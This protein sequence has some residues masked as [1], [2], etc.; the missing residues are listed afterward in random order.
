M[1][2]ATD[3]RNGR[4][5][6][7]ETTIGTAP[8][9]ELRSGTK[10]TDCAAADTGTQVATGVLPSDWLAAA[11]G[12]VKGKAGTWT[13]TGVAAAGAGTNAGHY[14]IKVGGVCK[15]QGPVGATGSGIEMTL[16]NVNIAENQVATITSFNVT[17]GNP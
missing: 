7:M 11:S 8:T 4:L 15:I 13:V 5:D 10:P 3:V 14:R 17:D 1:Q 2:L 6:S 9:L 16:D 12:G